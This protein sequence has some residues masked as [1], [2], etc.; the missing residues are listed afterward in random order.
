M[1]HFFD[2]YGGPYKDKYRFWTGFLLLIRVI[3]ALGV[4]IDP[5]DTASLDVLTSLLIVIMFM[6]Y[7]LKG[8]YRHFP[9]DYLEEFFILN[10]MF[11]ANMNV[12]TSN[13]TDKLK[14]QVSSIILVSISF[15]VFCGIIFYHVR[16]R[17]L[18][19]CL[20][21]S[22]TNVKKIFKKPPQTSS[23][24]NLELLLMHSGSTVGESKSTST[25]VVSVEMKQES[26]LFHIDD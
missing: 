23:S 10:L 2:A 26:I 22:I 9:L 4:S 8:I 16:D 24:N 20:H 12:R 13:E 1:K 21:Q 17:L 7:I 3:L 6:H 11:M 19:S 25:S 5:G 15:V 18:K 14:G